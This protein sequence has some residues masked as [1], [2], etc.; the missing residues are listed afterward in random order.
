[1]ENTSNTRP[2]REDPHPCV[3][4]ALAAARIAEARRRHQSRPK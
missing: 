1:M 4:R 3:R 2:E